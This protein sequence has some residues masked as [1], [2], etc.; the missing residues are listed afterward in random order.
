MTTSL[1]SLPL[2][3]RPSRI[4]TV[5]LL[6]A[7]LGFTALGVFMARDGEW[8]GY[9]VG[10]LFMLAVPFFVLQLH[11]RAAYLLLNEEGF[12]Y[13]SLFRAQAVRWV[14][15]EGFGVIAI[16][17]FR[18]VAW[19]FVPDH[20]RTGRARMLSQAVSGYEAALPDTYGLKPRELAHLLDALRQRWGEPPAEPFFSAG[21]V[22]R[23][24]Q[25]QPI[26]EPLPFDPA[27]DEATRRFYEGLVQQV[28]R[29]QGLR[30]RVEW[31][32][33]GSGYASFIEAWFY[34]ADDR[35]RLPGREKGHVGLVVLFSRLSRCFVLGQDGEEVVLRWQRQ[36]R[37]AQL[38]HRG[39]HHPPGDPAVR[40]PCDGS[41]D[42]GRPPTPPPARS[43]GSVAGDPPGADDPHR[44]AFPA[45]RRAVLLGRLARNLD[46]QISRPCMVLIPPGSGAA[47]KPRTAARNTSSSMQAIATS[48]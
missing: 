18:M 13:C 37:V 47:D 6:L 45:V 42:G 20:P 10:G 38:Q 12:T 25:G 21:E 15:V 40:W 34:P 44:S 33:Y 30:S 43:R 4:R 31:N 48:S 32:H 41:A 17:A 5:L 35:A 1:P 24:I 22:E 11:P 19:N 23:L 16:N 46:R 39:R 2:T 14:D 3:L 29:E 9:L 28:E 26:R 7:C 8:L 27:S 36:R